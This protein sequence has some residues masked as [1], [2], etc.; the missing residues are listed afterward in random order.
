M[1]TLFKGGHYSRG[2]SLRKYGI[3][4]TTVTTYIKTNDLRNPASNSDHTNRISMREFGIGC[5]IP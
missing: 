4:V 1:G 3:L 5:L 2:H